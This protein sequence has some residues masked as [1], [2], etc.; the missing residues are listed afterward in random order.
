[1]SQLLREEKI[2][3][4]TRMEA[5]FQRTRALIEAQPVVLLAQDTWEGNG[6][7]AAPA[8]DPR[9]T[10]QK[11]SQNLSLQS[12]L[13]LLP[14]NGTVLGCAR[15]EPF[16]RASA[17]P[18]ESRSQRLR[19]PRQTDVW[20]RLVQCLGA[21]PP[22][23]MVV[24]L[25]DART[26]MFPFF[27]ACKAS[28]THFLVQAAQNRRTQGEDGQNAYL[29]EIVRA[30]PAQ[31]RRPFAARDCAGGIQTSISFGE[32]AIWPPRNQQHACGD[33]L[34]VWA[35]V[36][37]HAIGNN[38][39]TCFTIVCHPAIN[40]IFILRALLSD[41]RFAGRHECEFHRQTFQA[42]KNFSPLPDFL[43]EIRRQVEAISQ[44]WQDASL[45]A[46][47]FCS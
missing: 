40:R 26:D 13:A 33:P 37:A 29:F 10:G 44:V 30:W 38:E 20:V 46:K 11:R 41:I 19:R 35:M 5:H 8:Q 15:Q 39:Q 22:E 2:A 27:Q 32:T 25:G 1:M 43:K 14:E 42:E 16:V 18:D 7:L 6:A 24:H 9:S 45:I 17:P 21:F 31:D 36:P 3:F 28:R 23:T 34:P 12:A 4:E 47:Q